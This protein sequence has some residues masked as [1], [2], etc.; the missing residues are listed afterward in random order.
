[1]QHFITPRKVTG[2]RA[3]AAILFYLVPLIAEKRAN[4]QRPSLS[5]RALQT[6]R[7]NHPPLSSKNLSKRLC[8]KVYICWHRLR[9]QIR[10]CTAERVS[11]AFQKHS[12]L[13][14]NGGSINQRLLGLLILSDIL[15]LLYLGHFVV[16]TC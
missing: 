11:P 2:A 14:S 16:A 9:L 5:D 1:M 6:Q 15:S 3:A 12:V 4:L 7:P 10:F 8:S 13:N